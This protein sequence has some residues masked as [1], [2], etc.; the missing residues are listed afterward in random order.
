M[1]RIHPHS[2]PV[3]SNPN[4]HMADPIFYL[5]H[6]Q[7]D[8]LWYMWQQRDLET[9][10]MAYSGH[11]QRHSMELAKLSDKIKMQGWAPEIEV[12]EVMNTEGDLLC[13][14]Y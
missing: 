2:P 5:H 11:N 12:N 7:L 3:V 10:F 13:Y 6:T 1:V 9:R 14:T 8:R 4:A